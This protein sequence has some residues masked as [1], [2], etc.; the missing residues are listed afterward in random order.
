[1]SLNR[2]DFVKTTAVAA[3][4]TAVG[5]TLPKNQKVAGAGINQFAAFAGQVVA[6]W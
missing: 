1:M 3:A 4:A 6:S 2:R 5:I